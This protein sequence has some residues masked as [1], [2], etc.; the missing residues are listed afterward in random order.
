[1]R[2]IPAVTNCD[3]RPA[4]GIPGARGG[5]VLLVVAASGRYGGDRSRPEAG[6]PCAAAAAPVGLPP[7]RA[8]A[9][10]P[11]RNGETPGNSGADDRIPDRSTLPRLPAPT[12]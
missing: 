12:A 3:F 2:G 10:L 9:K 6:E 8:R 7:G 5:L 1:M 11:L 4:T